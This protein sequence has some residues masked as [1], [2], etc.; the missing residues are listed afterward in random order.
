MVLKNFLFFVFFG[1]MTINNAAAARPEIAPRQQPIDITLFQK[2][3]TEI[4][5]ILGKVVGKNLLRKLN[6]SLLTQ[7]AKGNHNFRESI[8]ETLKK[9]DVYSFN[10]NDFNNLKVLLQAI[11]APGALA[12]KSPFSKTVKDF[13][14]DAKQSLNGALN[15]I[16]NASTSILALAQEKNKELLLQPIIAEEQSFTFGMSGSNQITPIAMCYVDLTVFSQT[17]GGDTA[18]LRNIGTLKLLLLAKAQVIDK[19]KVY[20]MSDA[21]KEK[22]A[23]A[24]LNKEQSKSRLS[25]SQLTNEMIYQIYD[26]VRGEI[27]KKINPQY[28]CEVINQ[29]FGR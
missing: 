20:S 16:L 18:I 14:T 24:M 28:N 22:L 4:N 29:Q 3:L 25:G 15:N 9:K 21:N 5:T 27:L 12:S 11:N 2:N 23:V 8:R 10:T 26:R 19:K 13:P 6:L 1:L 7:L 17:G